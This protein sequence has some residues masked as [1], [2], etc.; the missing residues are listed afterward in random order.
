MASSSTF[1]NRCSRSINKALVVTISIMSTNHC[2]TSSKNDCCKF[3]ID[4]VSCVISCTTG[5]I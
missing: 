2:P 4:A 1:I 5:I 3:V